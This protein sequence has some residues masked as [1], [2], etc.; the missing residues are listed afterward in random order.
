M[1]KIITTI[2]NIK[3]KTVTKGNRDGTTANNALL[4][5][6][7]LIFFEILEY[8]HFNFSLKT[9]FLDGILNNLHRIL[10]Q[11]LSRN[12][13]FSQ[14]Y[15]SLLGNLR[16]PINVVSVSNIVTINAVNEQI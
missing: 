4:L 8:Y 10:I 16:L 15:I 13:F 1:F 2:Y 5:S 12:E 7:N 9:L 6:F 14:T 11:I 3:I